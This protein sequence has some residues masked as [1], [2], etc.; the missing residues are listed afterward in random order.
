[1]TATHALAGNLGKREPA[2]AMYRKSI[3]VVRRAMK[4]A[5]KALEKLIASDR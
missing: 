1:M 2:I 5:K 3:A 4:R